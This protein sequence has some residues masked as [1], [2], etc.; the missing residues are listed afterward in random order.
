MGNPFEK[1]M[2]QYADAEKPDIDFFIRRKLGPKRKPSKPRPKK[3]KFIPNGF[4]PSKEFQ[5]LESERLMEE[6][7][8]KNPDKRPKNT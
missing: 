2:Q 7:Y 4:Q 5:R 6:F 3:K 1:E 8:V